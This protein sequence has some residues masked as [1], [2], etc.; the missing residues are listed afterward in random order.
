[1]LSNEWA[2]ATLNAQRQYEIITRNGKIA[3]SFNNIKIFE[4]FI[5]CDESILD[6]NGYTKYK[7]LRVYTA[8]SNKPV[9]PRCRILDASIPYLYEES[10][11]NKGNSKVYGDVALL[12]G[13]SAN[14]LVASSGKTLK[15]TSLANYITLDREGDTEYIKIYGT[16]F[17]SSELGWVSKDF[18]TVSNRDILA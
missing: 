2:V 11:I 12:K 9:L 17:G 13:I 14:Y 1:M 18:Q 3:E 5:I 15:I 16:I 4:H 7:K 6:I 8:N 10:E